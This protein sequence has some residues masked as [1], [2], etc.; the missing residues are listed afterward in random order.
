MNILDSAQTRRDLI[1]LLGAGALAAAGIAVAPKSGLA[2]PGAARVLDVAASQD[3]ARPEIVIGVPSNPAVLDPAQAGFS[4]VAAR[5]LYCIYDYLIESDYLA[6]DPPGL[7]T[8]LVPGLA[9]SWTRIDDLTFELKLRA[10]VL[11][12]D[13][14]A[15]TADDLKYTIERVTAPDADPLLQAIYSQVGSITTVEAID[16]LT[17]RLVTATPDPSLEVR[18]TYGMI[19]PVPQHYIEEV[20]IEAFAQKPIGTGPYKV[21]EFIPGDQL[22]LEAFDDYWGSKPAFSKVTFRIIPEVATRL[23]AVRSDECQIAV[24]IP[25]DQIVEI[26]NDSELATRSIA[27][28]NCHI[29]HYNTKHPHVAS[30]YLRQALNIG[31]DRQLLIDSLWRG[32]ADVMNS[33]QLERWGAFYNPDR[34]APAYDPDRARELLTQANYNGEEIVYRANP[35]YY[36]L[37]ADAAQVIVAMWQELGVNARVEIL[38]DLAA[39]PENLMIKAWSNSISPNDPAATFLLWWGKNGGPQKDGLWV[40]EDSRFNGELTDTVAGSLD[41]AAR[42]TAYQQ[43][44]DIWEDEAPA[45]ILYNQYETYVLRSDIAWQPYTIYGMDLREQAMVAQ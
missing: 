38:D 18:L 39:D 16:D 33:F 44:L 7:G 25:P 2:A 12:H 13:G 34:P 28:A 9:S 24:Q 20:G 11:F 6:S 17:V 8:E 4:V 1:R 26:Q 30:K 35:S 41:Q 10:G 14:A 40:P 36:M 37:G 27:I 45:S 22:V 21:A 42:V 31:Y 32:N 19:F 29:F 23:A 15:F 5:T 3:D 43:M